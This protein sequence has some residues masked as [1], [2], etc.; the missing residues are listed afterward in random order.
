MA[1][2][3]TRDGRGPVAYYV[4]AAL[5]HAEKQPT[6]ADAD[7][8]AAAAA[9]S[10]SVNELYSESFYE[11]GWLQR[12]ERADGRAFEIL[13]PE[14]ASA[15][16]RAEAKS[17][18]Q[19]AEVALEHGDLDAARNFVDR[20]DECLP[21][22]PASLN[23]RG[24]ILLAQKK[25]DEAETAFRDALA[26]DP[27]LSAAAYN[28]AQVAL[29]KR[30]GKRATNSNGFLAR[31][32]R[33]GENEPAEFLK[34]QIFLTSA[35]RAG[36][37]S[38]TNDGAVSVHRCNARALLRAGRLGICPCDRERGQEWIASARR[39]YPVALNAVFLQPLSD[40]AFLDQNGIHAVIAAQEVG[41]PDDGSP[42]S[43]ASAHPEA[44]LENGAELSPS[45]WV[46][47]EIIEL[48]GESRERARRLCSRCL[49]NRI[50]PTSS[51]GSGAHGV[52]RTDRGKS[53]NI[54]SGVV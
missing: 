33:E 54:G 34:D 15:A 27:K 36:Q 6:E 51:G 23:L 45:K 2:E 24:E 10:H 28:L 12:P 13:S 49:T 47:A 44:E 14:E 31:H 18:L 46:E 22:Q 11:I 38:A 20:A 25:M 35:R 50:S 9:F 4:R 26:V 8:A 52:L 19:S 1:D 48:A 21:R 3:L 32:R 42:I 5:A 16:T 7:L 30:I 17:H 40:L 29:Q 43:S 39:I 41:H 53:R 37:R